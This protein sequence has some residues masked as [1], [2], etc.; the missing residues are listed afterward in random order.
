MNL[1]AR[2]ETQ[3]IISRFRL[4]YRFAVKSCQIEIEVSKSTGNSIKP[5]DLRTTT[6]LEMPLPSPKVFARRT[7]KCRASVGIKINRN[8]FECSVPLKHGYPNLT[9]NPAS[10]LNSRTELS[11]PEKVEGDIPVRR[12][13]L[14]SDSR[15]TTR[16]AINSA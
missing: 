10:R 14:S 9:P 12:E 3:S 7:R 15:A 8:K 16:R 4:N 13:A 6:R 11:P 2:R 5:V 1:F